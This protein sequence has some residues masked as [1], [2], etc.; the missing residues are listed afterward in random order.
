MAPSISAPTSLL[1]V[2]YFMDIFVKKQSSHSLHL[3]FH[4]IHPKNKNKASPHKLQKYPKTLTHISEIVLQ[5]FYNSHALEL[6][7]SVKKHL[8]PY[9]ICPYLFFV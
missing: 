3:R 6:L 1:Q 9:F 8:P 5:C 4:V 2:A 7:L